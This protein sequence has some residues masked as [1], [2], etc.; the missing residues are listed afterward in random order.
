MIAAFLGG[1]NKAFIFFTY[2]TD[3]ETGFEVDMVELGL[4]F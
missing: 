3:F 2:D 4:G 1:G